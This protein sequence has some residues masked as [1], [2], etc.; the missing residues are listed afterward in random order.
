MK[1]TVISEDLTERESFEEDCLLRGECWQGSFAEVIH[2]FYHRV[3]PKLGLV[4][5]HGGHGHRGGKPRRGEHRSDRNKRSD[6]Y[7]HVE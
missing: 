7:S 1:S 3:A 4:V 6:G 2:N 5:I